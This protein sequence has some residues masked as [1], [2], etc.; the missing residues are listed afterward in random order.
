MKFDLFCDMKTSSLVEIDRCFGENCCL[1]RQGR[2]LESDDG[3]LDT[4]YYL[5]A[6]LVFRT[7]IFHII[8]CKY[9][10]ERW[11]E[12]VKKRVNYCTHVVVRMKTI[13]S[14]KRVR[15]FTKRAISFVMSRRLFIC[16]STSPPRRISVKFKVADF[17]KHLYGKYKF[18][19]SRTKLSSTLNEDLSKIFLFVSDDAKS[20]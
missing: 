12:A 17:Y 1:L 13:R 3:V 11:I 4:V 15:I 18:G 14:L 20:P 8:G 9:Y 7:P 6:L 2:I 5:A 10:H 16:I 19:Y